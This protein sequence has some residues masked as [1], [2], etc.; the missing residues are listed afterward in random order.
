MKRSIYLLILTGINLA[1][2]ATNSI[3][4]RAAVRQSI[5]NKVAEPHRERGKKELEKITYNNDTRYED[6]KN[7][8]QA[9]MAFESIYYDKKGKVKN[10][11][12]EKIVFGTNGECMVMNEGAKDEIWYIFNYAD[13]A[14]YM[15]M[16]N[17]KMAM[18]MP[19]IN[20][21]KM[22]EK[23]AQKEAQKI[24]EDNGTGWTS[25]DEKAVINGY[26]CKKYVYTYKENNKYTTMDA[27]FSNDVK[28]TDLSDNY[29]LGAK[30]S[31]Y[32]FPQQTAY[33]D[34]VSGFMVRSILYNKKG[35]M[36]Y[37]RDLKEFKKSADAKYFDLSPFAINNIL[38]KL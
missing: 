9:T 17:E 29:L 28:M 12:V 13:K 32:K 34:M 30:L 27:W 14:N 16:V 24:E 25:T 7:K 36:E 23:A 38:D 18:K 20:M 8:V 31:S 26:N 5:E 1:L 35:E 3:A 10:T 4:Q 22:I 6:A 21:K 15:V 11:S 37:Q 19:L 2:N 33:K